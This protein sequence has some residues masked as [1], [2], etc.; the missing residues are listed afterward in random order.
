MNSS[1]LHKTFIDVCMDLI[2]WFNHTGSLEVDVQIWETKRAC[3]HRPFVVE[4]STAGCGTV[5]FS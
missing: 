1:S 3:I 2:M 5:G 4:M